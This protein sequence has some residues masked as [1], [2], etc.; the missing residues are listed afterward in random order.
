M[1]STVSVRMGY[2]CRSSKQPQ[3]INSRRVISTVCRKSLQISWAFFNMSLS[4]WECR[5]NDALLS[6]ELLVTVA[7]ETAMVMLPLLLLLLVFI[8]LAAFSLSCNM[9]NLHCHVGS[10]IMAHWLFHCGLW[11]Q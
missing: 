1:L 2:R 6:G 4:L 8:D 9:Q 10:F 3:Y 11:A 7:K 5:Q